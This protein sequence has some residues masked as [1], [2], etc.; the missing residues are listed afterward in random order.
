VKSLALKYLL[1]SFLKFSASCAAFCSGD[2]GGEVWGG[3]GGASSPSAAG[4][5]VPFV[6][7][8][9]T[10]TVKELFGGGC[11]GCCGGGDEGLPKLGGSLSMSME[12]LALMADRVESRLRSSGGKFRG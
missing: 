6:P 2:V 5:A 3:G 12:F 9:C 8:V 4:G 11:D 7:F 1:P 10:G